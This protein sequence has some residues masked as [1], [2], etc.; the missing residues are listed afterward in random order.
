MIFKPQGYQ[1]QYLT[2]VKAVY[3]IQ[4]ENYITMSSCVNISLIMRYVH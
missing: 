4:Y 2:K 3:D 1:Y